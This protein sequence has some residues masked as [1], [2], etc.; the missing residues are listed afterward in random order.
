MGTY[1]FSDIL[2]CDRRSGKGLKGWRPLTEQCL[3][4]SRLQCTRFRDCSLSEMQSGFLHAAQTIDHDAAGK[5]RSFQDGSIG[6]PAKQA[7]RLVA[8]TSGAAR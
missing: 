8:N 4:S 6:G 1:R 3:D 5:R 7:R 2:R